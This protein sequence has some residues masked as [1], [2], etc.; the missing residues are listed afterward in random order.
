MKLHGKYGIM[1]NQQSH[2]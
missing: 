2:K 1:Q